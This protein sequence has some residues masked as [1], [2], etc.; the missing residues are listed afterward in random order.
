MGSITDSLQGD[1][2][3]VFK[4]PEADLM[5]LKLVVHSTNLELFDGGKYLLLVI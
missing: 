5:T 3:T 4:L 2:F 1:L